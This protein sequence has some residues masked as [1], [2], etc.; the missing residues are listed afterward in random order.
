MAPMLLRP[1][2]LMLA[3][4]AWVASA[5]GDGD[6]GLSLRLTRGVLPALVICTLTLVSAV[7]VHAVVT[8]RRAP[9]KTVK[10]STKVVKKDCVLQRDDALEKAAAASKQ[11]FPAGVRVQTKSRGEGVVRSYAAD[12]DMYEIELV[13]SGEGTAKLSSAEIIEPRVKD[14]YI[15]PI[16]SCAGIRLE[17][18]QIAGKPFSNAGSEAQIA[19][20]NP[21]FSTRNGTRSRPR[22]DVRR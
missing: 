4:L 11:R 2:L 9:A 5:D 8:R 12:S 21:F 3:S 10:A 6:W 22:V 18:A 17:S 7:A 14:F 1:S 15:Y 19:T 20:L 16:K 13:E